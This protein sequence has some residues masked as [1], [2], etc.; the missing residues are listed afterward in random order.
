MKK[1]SYILAILLAGMVITGCQKDLLNSLPSTNIPD[2][3]AFDNASRIA[4]QVNGLYSVLKNG[5]FAGGKVIIA[6]EIR[7]EDY[8]NLGSNNV[9]LNAS[10]RM[11]TTGESQEVKEI[12]SQGYMSINNANLVIAGMLEKIMKKY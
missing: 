4:S 8:V 12:W 11:I 3:N 10:W 9:T 5:K 6:N 1:Y 7:G 2:E